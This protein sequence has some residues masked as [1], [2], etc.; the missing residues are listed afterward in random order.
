ML[1]IEVQ[2]EGDTPLLQHRFGEQA[3]QTKNTRPIHVRGEDPREA[4]EAV[5]YRDKDGYLFFPITWV[6][7]MLREAGGSHK[8]RGSRKS[9][10]YIV[11]AAVRA[12][13]DTVSILN[14]DGKSRVKDFEVDSRPVTIPATKGRIMRHRPRMNQWSAKFDVRL[15]DDLLDPGTLHMLLNE[16]GQAFGLG[17]FRPEKGGPFGTFRVVRFQEK[18]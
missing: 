6:L 8:Q 17:D 10:K 12:V 13:A 1:L 4:A 11:P 18:K 9:L 15:K 14:G 7:R 3:E 5:C 2:I 16:G